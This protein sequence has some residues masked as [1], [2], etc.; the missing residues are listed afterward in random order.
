M[1]REMLRSFLALSQELTSAIPRAQRIGGGG[2][3]W[4]PKLLPYKFLSVRLGWVTM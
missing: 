2:I 1:G 4:L 3:E